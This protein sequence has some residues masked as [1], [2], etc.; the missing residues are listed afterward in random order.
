MQTLGWG[1]PAERLAWAAV[2]FGCDGV[3]VLAVAH[4]KVGALREVLPQQSVGVLVRAALPGTGRVVEVDRSLGPLCAR[5][6][7]S[8]REAR[9]Q[10]P[11]GPFSLGR[12]T[13]P[14]QP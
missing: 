13:R 8:P 9:A 4:R 6:P 7:R 2:E 10:G 14:A 3:Q 1:F 11:A 12:P 5:T